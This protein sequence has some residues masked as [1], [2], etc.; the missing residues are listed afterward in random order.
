MDWNTRPQVQK[1]QDR[2]TQLLSKVSIHMEIND[3][4]LTRRVAPCCRQSNAKIVSKWHSYDRRQFMKL[5]KGSISNN[6]NK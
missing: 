2:S 3:R 4:L 6:E 1:E 5:L